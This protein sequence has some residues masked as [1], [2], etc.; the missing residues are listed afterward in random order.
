MNLDLA[1]VLFVEQAIFEF[2]IRDSEV[3]GINQFLRVTAA[4]I[5]N[6]GIFY[7]QVQ[8]CGSGGIR[9][10]SGHSTSRVGGR[11]GRLT[12]ISRLVSRCCFRSLVVILIFKCPIRRV[13]HDRCPRLSK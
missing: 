7:R 10:T 11:V 4:N 5:H 3:Q 9:G 2:R 6:I 1:R 8:D 13:T 12:T